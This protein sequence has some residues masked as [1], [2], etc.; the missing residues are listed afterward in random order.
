MMDPIVLKEALTNIEAFE[1]TREW[2]PFRPGIDISYIYTAEGDGASAAFLKY[3]AGASVARHAHAGF[4]HIF[5]LRG[6]QVD[7]SGRNGAGTV[8]INP[9]GSSHQV[10]SPEGC[11]VL[12]IWEKPI[13]ILADVSQPSGAS[14]AERI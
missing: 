3:E 5:I 14:G 7:R 11:I 9:P 6:S 10:S 13:V 4:E 1:K 2:K 12:I 8:I